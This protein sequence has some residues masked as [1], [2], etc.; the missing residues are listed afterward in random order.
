[1]SSSEIESDV[2]A[3]IAAAE[4]EDPR[5]ETEFEMLNWTPPSEIDSRHDLVGALRGAAEHVLGESPPLG[6]FPGGTDAPYFSGIA[7]IPTVPSF[8]P[9]LLTQAHSPN[10]SI[11]VESII[12]AARMY[13]G[14]AVGFVGA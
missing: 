3:F 1:M 2:R 10:E 5:L 6:I 4:H 11:L 7:G 8:G 14:T 13:A 12:Q 9:G